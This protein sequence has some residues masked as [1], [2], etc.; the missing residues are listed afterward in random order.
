[1]IKVY[2]AYK[3]ER[4][5]IAGLLHQ[6]DDEQDAELLAYARQIEASWIPSV[7]KACG[8]LEYEEA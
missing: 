1:M 2:L 4:Y 6:P 8:T 7:A 3:G 5:R